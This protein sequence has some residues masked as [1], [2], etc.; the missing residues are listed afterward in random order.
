MRILHTG[1]WHVGK[2]IGGIPRTEEQRAV[3]SE[4]ARVAEE[5]AVDLVLV[6]GD[7]FDTASP[8]PEAERIVYRA[9]LDLG[10]LAPVVVVPGNHD[11]ERRLD[12]VAPLFE[13]AGVSIRAFVNNTAPLE[14]T[15]PLGERARIATVP[16]LSQRHIVKADQL[17]D[18][19]AVDH[20]GI[21]RERL[22]R[23]V[24]A[25][26]ASFDG[27]A[28]NLVLAHLTIV[29]ALHG[30]GERTAQT[31]FDYTID[32]GAFPDNAHYVAL[33]HLHRAQRMPGM[34]PVH[35]CGSPLQLDFSDD[36]SESKQI[37]LIEASETTPATVTEVPL[38]SG[39]RLRTLEGTLES[40]ESL[41]DKT[42][43]ALLRVIVKEH[44]RVG[45]ADDVRALFPNAVK[46][47]VRP[48]LR[49][50]TARP[51]RSHNSPHELF[52]Q[53]LSERN[54]DD[55]DLVRLFG[56]LYEDCA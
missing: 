1:D 25:L 28:V 27:S 24:E 41:R 13:N 20:G 49:E 36:G 32:A 15:T 45:L 52:R 10:R 21:Y 40:L 19:Q 2:G 30:G 29:G 42:G 3:L 17:M 31:I 9:L 11:N 56:T 6:A 14:I 50:E 39:R 51:Q 4:I 37:L 23:I 53:Y 8:S 48:E 5:Q 22:R 43:D 12:A 7:L 46:V 34:C 38:R 54:V 18:L 16:W 26:V 33:G 35:Y 55:P 47:L 44:I